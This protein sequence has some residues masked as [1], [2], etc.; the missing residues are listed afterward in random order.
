M[1]FS[2]WLITILVNGVYAV[3]FTNPLPNYTSIQAGRPFDIEWGD[4]DGPVD[5][6]L[7]DGSSHRTIEIIGCK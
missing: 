4:A 6:Q 5:I 1:Y 2:V 3:E 7:V